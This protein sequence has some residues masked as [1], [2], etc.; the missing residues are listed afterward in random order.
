MRDRIASVARRSGQGRLEVC[1]AQSNR[2][3]EGVRQPDGSIGFRDP[4]IPI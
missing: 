3:G 2:I 4:T 1:D